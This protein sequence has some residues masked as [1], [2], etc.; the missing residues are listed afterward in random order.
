MNARSPRLVLT[1]GHAS[2]VSVAI[3]ATVLSPGR[4]RTVKK[5]S[6]FVRAVLVTMDLSVSQLRQ[7]SSAP[8]VQGG[9]VPSVKIM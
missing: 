2:T 3:L 5:P 6:T 1:M 8:V 7:G 4:G 9:L